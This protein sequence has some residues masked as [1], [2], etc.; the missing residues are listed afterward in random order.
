[1]KRSLSVVSIT[2]WIITLG[3]NNNAALG[4][5]CGSTGNGRQG[6]V[7]LGVKQDHHTSA[8]DE[9]VSHFSHDVRIKEAPFSSDHYLGQVSDHDSGHG[10]GHHKNQHKHH[11]DMIE[12]KKVSS[13]QAP[14]SHVIPREEV[15]ALLKFGSDEKQ[16]IVNEFG[17][18]TLAAAILTMPLWYLAMKAVD[19]LCNLNP[20]LDPH[21]SVYDST[22]KI[23]SRIYL[24]MI[25]SYPEVSGEGIDWIREE[26][27]KGACLFVA[28]HASWIDIPILCTV[29]DPVFKFIAKD[30]LKSA[31]CI[32]TQLTGGNHILLNRDDRRSQLR[33]FKQGVEWLKKGVPVM[34]FPEGQR[35]KDGRLLDF[36]GGI[37]SMAVKSGVPIV[38]ITISNAHAVMPKYA[39]FPIQSGAGKL[40]VHVHNP[41]QTQG[42]TELE[43][44][45]MVRSAFLSQLPQD[46][47]PL[48]PPSKEDGHDKQSQPQKPILMSIT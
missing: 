10:H 27:G 8:K 25:G 23:W 31:P 18:Y 29:L 40:S 16:K 34:A 26:S 22:G 42:K 3:I 6:V 28:N 1:M 14:P 17:M 35:S 7:A 44:S 48:V 9:I 46:Q 19:A 21:R 32:G 5:L 39:L 45:E 13:S 2:T 33:T 4:F 37:F 20:D 38:P 36:K 12:V 43:L 30:N 47:H 24:Q 15:H 41:I 11:N